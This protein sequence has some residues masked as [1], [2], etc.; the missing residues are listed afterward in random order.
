M[1]CIA[2]ITPEYRKRMYDL[3]NLYGRKYN[4]QY[5]VVC[6]DEKSKQL[7]EDKR[8]IIPMKPGSPEKYDGEYKR[9]GTQ[10][11][12]VA[13]EPMGGKRFIK[14]TDQRKKVDFAHFIKELIP[15]YPK[16]KK[17]RLVADNLNTHFESSFHETFSAKEAS[18]ILKKIEFHYTPKHGS[19][20]NMAEIEINM[21]DRE[22]LNRRIGR[23]DILKKEIATWAKQRNIKKKKIIWTFTKQKADDKLSK[24]YA[25]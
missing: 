2:T 17:I 3:L 22:C 10:N 18:N 20:L 25:P 8:T 16:S 24:H 1:W 15:L 9:M 11:I 21:M 7:L 23:K 5:P 19:W 14:V 13:V 4:G 6:V 12:F